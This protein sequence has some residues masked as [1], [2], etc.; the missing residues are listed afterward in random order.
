MYPLTTSCHLP[1]F[2]DRGDGDKID[3]ELKELHVTLAN[4]EED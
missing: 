1:G 4:V 2:P 3:E